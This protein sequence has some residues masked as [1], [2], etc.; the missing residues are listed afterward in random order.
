MDLPTT[1]GAP[2]H[3]YVDGNVYWV[4]PMTVLAMA[5]VMQWLDD[6]LPG[7]SERKMPPKIGDDASQAAL[8]SFPGRVLLT[9]L[10]LKDNGFS[11]TAAA[12]V[13]PRSPEDDDD[14]QKAKE[15]LRV[16]DIFMSRRRTRTI[17]EGGEDWSEL[18]LDKNYASLV[19]EYGLTEIGNLTLDQF[20]W[21]CSAGTADEFGQYDIQKRLD[22]WRANEL[23]KVMEMMQAG[24]VEQIQPSE[25]PAVIRM[26]MDRGLVEE[27]PP[28]T[29]L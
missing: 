7:R 5:T 24:A 29:T 27:I 13:V 21:L 25:R 1:L 12:E 4:R 8:K 6:V 14:E 22:E 16:H 28:S 11:Y 18:W 19:S 20:E 2:R 9:W 15:W 23:P 17:G 26:A 3:C 10:A